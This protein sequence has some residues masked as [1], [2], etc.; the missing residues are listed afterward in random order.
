MRSMAPR[1]RWPDRADARYAIC[2]AATFLKWSI[3]DF[4]PVVTV[5]RSNVSSTSPVTG[6]SAD[7]RII[8]LF[9][10]ARCGVWHA[11]SRSGSRQ[12]SGSSR[13]CPRCGADR[14][15]QIDSRGMPCGRSSR[16][17]RRNSPACSGW[18]HQNC[19]NRHER[20][21]GLDQPHQRHAGCCRAAQQRLDM[22]ARIIARPGLVIDRT[23]TPPGSSS[24]GSR[25]RA[26]S[27][28][29][30]RLGSIPVAPLHMTLWS[31]EPGSGVR[32]THST[33]SRGSSR[34]MIS[35]SRRID[36]GVSAGH[37][38]VARIG[39][40][41][42]LLPSEQHLAVFGDLVLRLLSRP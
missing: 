9:G 35:I 2:S 16:C 42:L 24:R 36:S 3:A 40:D 10:R 20:D 26:R 6:V 14:N 38:D 13:S 12:T 8:A 37:E 4:A 39:E 41:A 11:G 30:L 15:C 21:D 27:R 33:M 28:N 32:M 29:L 23:A 7:V 34:W 22:L 17:L 5:S 25:R 19:A 18:M 1:R 31:S